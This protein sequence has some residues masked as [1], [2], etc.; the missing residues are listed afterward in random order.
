MI[1]AVIPFDNISEDEFSRA[2]S[3]VDSSAYTGYAPKVYFVQYNGT[4]NSL[5]E[6]VGFSGETKSVAGVV[7]QASGYFGFASPDLWE[8]LRN[9][10]TK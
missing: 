5:A 4:A 7:I 8:W 3:G 10:W 9:N 2:I 6:K 1:Y